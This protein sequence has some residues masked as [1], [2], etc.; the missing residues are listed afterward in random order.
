M[1]FFFNPG[2]GLPSNLALTPIIQKPDFIKHQR[3]YSVHCTDTAFS[4]GTISAFP[5]F[6]ILQAPS[7][8]ISNKKKGPDYACTSVSECSGNLFGREHTNRLIRQGL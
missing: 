4:L 5:L 6:V 1:P 7:I 3:K 8:Q 2:I